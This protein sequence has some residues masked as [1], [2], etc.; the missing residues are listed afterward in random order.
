MKFIII[1]ILFDDWKIHLYNNDK[2]ICIK[3]T[4][5]NDYIS[6]EFKIIP[7]C[8]NDY[9][10]YNNFKNNIFKNEL[11]NIEILNNKSKF[12][13][14]MLKSFPN[15]I[16]IIYYYNFENETYKNNI[17]LSTKMIQ[18]PNENFG[19]NGIKI[20]NKLENNIKNH[21]IQ[22]YIDHTENFVGHFIILNGIIHQK[23]YF[24]AQS[25]NKILRGTICNYKITKNLKISDKIFEKI[26]NNL[27]Y[28]GFACIDFII[29]NKNIILFEINPRPGGSLI[30]NK[31]YFNLF[32]DKL[33]I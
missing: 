25:M 5:I 33:I 9:I 19:S 12:G 6:D 30:K 2:C 7:I 13:K 18:K 4:D 17:I 29:N 23:I 20:I 8:V 27:N 11:K 21:I 16:P 1:T 10:K 32:L 22:K 3:E 28:S 14:F 31:L 26:F 24:Y 15:N